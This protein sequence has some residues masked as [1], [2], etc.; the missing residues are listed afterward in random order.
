MSEIRDD[1]MLPPASA[2]HIVVPDGEAYL[3]LPHPHILVGKARGVLS[4]PL[5]HLLVD[6]YSP[7]L[8]LGARVRFFSD[9]EL[10]TYY[11]RDAREY[12]TAFSLEHLFAIE[13]I[14]FLLSSKYMALGVSAYK[15]AIGDARVHVYGD[16][17]SFFRS[18]EEAVL[19]P[20]APPMPPSST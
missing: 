13:V 17:A 14:H 16:R 8:Q 4:L 9:Y 20:T 19:E 15:H 11:T 10:L 7:V 5:A 2:H 12:L 6:F 3:W 18:Y 1:P